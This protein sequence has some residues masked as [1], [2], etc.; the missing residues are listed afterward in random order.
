M[1]FM[2]KFICS[3]M[4]LDYLQFATVIQSLILQHILQFLHRK[5]GPTAVTLVF[6]VTL[7]E[8]GTAY[9]AFPELVYYHTPYI[10]TGKL[11]LSVLYMQL[12]E[13]LLVIVNLKQK[14]GSFCTTGNT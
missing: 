12:G 7:F 5:R 2:T 1:A 3:T 13:F 14:D 6:F 10:A 4:Y 9:V 11:R 8:W